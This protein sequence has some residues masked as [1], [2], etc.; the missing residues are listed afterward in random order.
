MHAARVAPQLPII[1][2]LWQFAEVLVL[3]P[4]ACLDYID[5]MYTKV[6]SDGEYAGF[7]LAGHILRNESMHDKTDP[8]YAHLPVLL[9][10][11]LAP[12]QVCHSPSLPV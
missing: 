1:T 4:A 11:P 7:S 12:I 10:R 6:D 5:A 9:T 8:E 3:T 2:N